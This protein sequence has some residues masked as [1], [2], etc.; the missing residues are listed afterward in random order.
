MERKKGTLANRV[1]EF[2]M[3]GYFTI[4]VISPSWTCFLIVG[5]G[6]H[7]SDLR[8]RNRDL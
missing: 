3:Q 7:S 8:V 5:P 4:T 1:E 2:E 6:P